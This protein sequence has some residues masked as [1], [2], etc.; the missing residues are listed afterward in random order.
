MKGICL[1]EAQISGCFAVNK[2]A[3]ILIDHETLERV[4]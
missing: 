3:T 2:A 1:S 4:R